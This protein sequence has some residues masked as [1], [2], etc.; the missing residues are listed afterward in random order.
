MRFAFASGSGCSDR[1]PSLQSSSQIPFGSFTKP[2]TS[3]L[4]KNSGQYDEKERSGASKQPA[5]AS[6][7]VPGLREADPLRGIPH[8]QEQDRDDVDHGVSPPSLAYF[9]RAPPRSR[10]LSGGHQ[11]GRR[12][13]PVEVPQDGLDEADEGRPDAAVGVDGTH[14]RA[15]T[16]IPPGYSPRR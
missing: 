12:V 7:P 2:T 9:Y 6:H 1:S 13:E 3:F 16:V 11:S 10:A 15:S 4:A 5:P 8:E 14:R